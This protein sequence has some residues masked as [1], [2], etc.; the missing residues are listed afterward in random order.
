MCILLEYMDG[1]DLGQYIKKYGQ[2]DKLI[3]ETKI[4]NFFIQA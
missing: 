2:V 1:G 3:D 4:W